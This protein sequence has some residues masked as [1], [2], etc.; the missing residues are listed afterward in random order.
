MHLLYQSFGL[1]GK[2]V[3]TRLEHENKWPS[4]NS[5]KF[6]IVNQILT[7]ISIAS[8]SMTLLEAVLRLGGP[9]LL[10]GVGRSKRDS[11]KWLCWNSIKNLER[12]AKRLQ[13]CWDRSGAKSSRFTKVKS[14]TQEPLAKRLP[15]PPPQSPATLSHGV[16]RAI[17]RT[18]CGSLLR[19][20]SEL[21][22]HRHCYDGAEIKG[23]SVTDHQ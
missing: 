16:S 7:G 23:K 11:Y 9:F 12:R 2:L 17:K 15:P 20:K 8:F 1:Y 14:E 6:T 21:K 19:T 22:L 4:S 13:K 18:K 10:V 5:W 3:S